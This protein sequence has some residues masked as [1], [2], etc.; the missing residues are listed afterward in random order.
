MGLFAVC[1]YFLAVFPGYYGPA[2]AS[3]GYLSA[4]VD[5]VLIR[6]L[7]SQTRTQLWSS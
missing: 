2:A 6:T 4:L 5:A 1:P 3:P 7:A